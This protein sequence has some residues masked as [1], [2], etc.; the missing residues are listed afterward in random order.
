MWDTDDV[1][2]SDVAVQNP[3][4]VNT[5]VVTVDGLSVD[6]V[7]TCSRPRG[8]LTAREVQDGP[9]FR[10]GLAL[11]LLRSPSPSHEGRECACPFA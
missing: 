10:L 9:C 5:G 4:R 6:G 3:S 1:V 7:S 2:P 11:A 8:Q